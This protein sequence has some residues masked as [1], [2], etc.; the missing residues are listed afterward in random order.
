MPLIKPS[1]E[2][3][4]KIPGISGQ[5][6][7][8]INTNLTKDQK[9]GLFSLLFVTVAL[10][11][12]FTAVA[13]IYS[14]GEFNEKNKKETSEYYQKCSKESDKEPKDLGTFLNSGMD[15]A[16]FFMGLGA[17]LIFGFIDNAGLFYGMSYLDPVFS[18]EK[19]PWV[20]GKGGRR[21][22]TGLDADGKLIYRYHEFMDGKLTSAEADKLLG[23]ARK[24][25][26]E[27]KRDLKKPENIRADINVNET[28]YADPTSELFLGANMTKQRFITA[29]SNRDLR[30]ETYYKNIDYYKRYKKDDLRPHE[31]QKKLEH[32]RLS[33]KLHK[34]KGFGRRFVDKRTPI[35]GSVSKPLSE[36]GLSLGAK[37][38]IKE[39][40]NK[41]KLTRP[42]PGADKSLAEAAM[43]GWT[44]GSLTAAGIGNTYSDFLGSFLSTFIG[45][46]IL[47]S[48]GLCTTSL[49][50][51]V[52]GVT[53]GCILGLMFGRS[54]FTPGKK[55]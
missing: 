55:T 25:E 50:S 53:I 44:P 24:L 34:I 37:Q 41:I 43:D 46:M 9:Y 30:E 31:K 1:F 21:Y 39:L 23:A 52:V 35:P 49:I 12:V 36:L 19:V 47:V 29:F 13:Y 42:W 38:K 45:S 54:S 3:P 26:R 7:P 48:S 33:K 11:I 5:W 27:Y 18:P 28:A 20:Y 10:I 22:Y 14:R 8:F 2:I 4:G 51:E 40:E 32:K 17:G 6:G 15:V 16:G